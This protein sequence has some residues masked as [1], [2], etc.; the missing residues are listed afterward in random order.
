ML[1][2]GILAPWSCS[3]RGRLSS[4]TSRHKRQ[5]FASLIFDYPQCQSLLQDSCVPVPFMEP[6]LTCT[7][8]ACPPQV[9]G[10]SSQCAV[11][12]EEWR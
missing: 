10:S 7:L 2:D 8:L 11:W 4:H 9:D 12:V 5:A 3:R 1:T 6:R